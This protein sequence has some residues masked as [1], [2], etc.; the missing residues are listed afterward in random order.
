MLDGPVPYTVEPQDLRDAIAEIQRLRNQL[1][2]IVKAFTVP[3]MFPG[4]HEHVKRGLKRE[5]STLY[6]AIDDACPKGK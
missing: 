6:K 3:G 4:Y 1:E 5:W 2:P